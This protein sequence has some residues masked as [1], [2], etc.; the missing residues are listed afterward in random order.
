MALF[1]SS[2]PGIR[3]RVLPRF[4][5]RVVADTMMSI[6]KSGATYT[7]CV[8]F[9]G[10]TTSGSIASGDRD[11]LYVP[12]YDSDD[13]S[14][15]REPVSAFY[16]AFAP[17][18][19]SFVTLG[20]DSTL[21]N[22]RVLTAGTGLSVADGGAGTTVTIAISDAELLALAG[23]TSAADKVPYFTGSGTAAVADFTAFGRSLVDDA[24]AS[25]GRTTLGLGTIAT[26]NANA[27]ALTGGTMSGVT[28]GAAFTP[29]ASD[30]AALGTSTLMWSDLF[31]ASGA[32]V[33]F[34]NGDVTITHSAN[35][36]SFAG[37]SSG[38]FFDTTISITNNVLLTGY[39]E[40]S[41]IAAPS[42]PAADKLLLYAKDDGGVTKGYIKNS[43]GTETPLGGSGDVVGPASSTDNAV[44]RFDGTTGKLLQNSAFVVDDTGHVSSFG[45]NIVFPA[46]QASSANANTLDDYE[47]GTWT[48]VL[49]F[50]TPG[51]LSVTYAIQVGAY[52]KVGSLVVATAVIATSAFTHTTAAGNC[53]IT[54]LPFAA[55]NVANQNFYSALS[56][57]GITKATYTSY[58][59]RLASNTSLVDFVGSASAVGVAL[60]DAADVP[61]GGGP[62][63]SFDIPYFSA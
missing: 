9:A 21:T 46:S 17:V 47:E 29:T 48:P 5:A 52:R 45:G 28:V 63:F 50:A 19:A 38:Y 20:T 33:N 8:T 34:N 13:G 15:S 30:G 3:V 7:F 11:N 56:F 51:N 41:E 10:L 39:I 25:A 43:A 6:T 36:L 60:V 61:T 32:V 4:P 27:V 54:G 16:S 12:L 62:V 24:D 14:Y 26:Q 35:T 42:S 58:V 53:Q 22:E 57:Q 44:A 55:A 49:T 23:L 59:A 2:R 1:S 31:L 37:A 18:D 40:L